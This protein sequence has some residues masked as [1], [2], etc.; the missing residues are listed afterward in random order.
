MT[1]TFA[2]HFTAIANILVTSK[3]PQQLQSPFLER[4]HLVLVHPNVD[5]K[6]FIRWK[7]RDIHEKRAQRKQDIQ[8]L[9]LSNSI[10][11]TLQLHIDDIIGRLEKGQSTLDE[12]NIANAFRPDVEKLGDA[13]TGS[14]GPSYAQMVS[15]LFEDIRKTVA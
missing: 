5:K 15:S 10:N 14:D 7:Q 4:R 11:H 6:S 13:P 1:G 8:N 12:G 3:V 9:K 2:D